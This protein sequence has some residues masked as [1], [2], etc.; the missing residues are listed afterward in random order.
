MAWETSYIYDADIIV[1]FVIERFFINTL[2][3]TL[4]FI[5]YFRDFSFV[6]IYV[7]S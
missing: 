2:A 4:L 5:Y 6:I 7:L 3:L 1:L